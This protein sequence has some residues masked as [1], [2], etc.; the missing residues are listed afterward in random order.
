MPSLSSLAVERHRQLKALLHAVAA[1][2]ANAEVALRVHVPLCG[3]LAPPRR[4]RHLVSL[5]PLIPFGVTA[6]EL[7]LILRVSLHR[8]LAPPLRE[9]AQPHDSNS[10]DASR[11]DS[12]RHPAR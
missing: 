2:V 5:H 3:A 11:S 4:R 1:L 8:A 7:V 10:P 6:C 12:R 9:L